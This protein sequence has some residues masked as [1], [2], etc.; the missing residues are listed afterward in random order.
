[1]NSRVGADLVTLGNHALDG[2]RVVVNAAPVQ[3]VEEEGGLH[4][5]VAKKVEHIIGVV[6][7]AI[8]EGEG[9]G[10]GLGAA[11][12]DA[13]GGAPIVSDGGRGGEAREGEGD[14]TSGH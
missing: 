6:E 2:A 11:S 5:G 8:I 1:M 7:G 3:P 12:D 4:A 10:V 14:K 13:G 9:H